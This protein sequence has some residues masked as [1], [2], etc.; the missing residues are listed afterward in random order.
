MLHSIRLIFSSC[1]F[2]ASFGTVCA[3]TVKEADAGV[4][5][6]KYCK[7]WGG[8]L[9]Q[10]AKS[11]KNDA[12]RTADIKAANGKLLQELKGVRIFPLDASRDLQ[13]LTANSRS[14]KEASLRNCLQN[15][16]G[17]AFGAGTKTSVSIRLILNIGGVDPDMTVGQD[18]SIEVSPA[19]HLLTTD[20]LQAF[21]KQWGTFCVSKPQGGSCCTAPERV[22]G[23]SEY[24]KSAEACKLSAKIC[25]TM[26]QCSARQEECKK[27][28][29]AKDPRCDGAACKRC[30]SDYA[31]CS[32]AAN[33]ISS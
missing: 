30:T 25:N 11:A 8:A 6:E 12:Q 19:S 3:Q 17:A 13:A 1:L 31:A 14:A 9:Q 23:Y 33:K 22:S 27:R 4:V 21:G 32:S 24:C 2:M 18:I 26:V 20:L 15:E 16:A 10:S 5:F 28:E 29:M 7:E